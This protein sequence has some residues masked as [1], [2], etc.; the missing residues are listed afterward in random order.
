[1]LAR[2][3]WS[4]AKGRFLEHIT[5]TLQRNSSLT[6]PST[7]AP[8]LVENAGPIIEECLA[9]ALTDFE[10]EILRHPKA[11]PTTPRGA[12]RR[13][14]AVSPSPGPSESPNHIPSLS[15]LHVQ[16]RAASLLLRGAATNGVEGVSSTTSEPRGS[17]DGSTQGRASEPAVHL[18]EPQT[19]EGSESQG[20]IKM[21]GEGD[22][23]RKSGAPTQ[24]Q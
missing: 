16:P 23:E 5:N 2:T 4:L 24:Q 18:Q 10:Q 6:D 19:H 8:Q 3:A 11:R 14:Q 12:R 9:R 20:E 21:E 1:V 15:E 13:S 17:D 7:L 22:G